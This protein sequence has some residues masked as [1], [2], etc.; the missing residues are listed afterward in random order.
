MVY[1][2]K[3][4]VLG[5]LHSGRQ[6]LEQEGAKK[7]IDELVERYCINPAD[8]KV[9]FSPCAQNY[10]IY[11]L[12]NQKLPDAA[13]AQLKKAGVKPENIE[14]SGIDTVTDPRF[15]SASAGDKTTRFA[16]IT[17]K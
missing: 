14:E 1:D 16:I 9:F 4:E 2:P 15:P 10:E 17:A 5:L 12:E 13:K 8:L 7:F 6:N 11:A 3:T